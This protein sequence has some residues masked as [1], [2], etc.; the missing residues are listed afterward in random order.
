MSYARIS[1]WLRTRS[2]L[3]T[4]VTVAPL[5]VVILGLTACV[6]YPIGD[7]EKSKV[8]SE[9]VG[10][11][12]SDDSILFFRPYDTR[13]YLISAFTYSE[14]DGQYEAKTRIDYKAWLTP[15]GDETFITMQPLTIAHFVGLGERPPYF[16]AQ[17]RLV[18]D[19][20]QLRLVNAKNVSVQEATNS[21]ELE[22]AI[23]E[24]MSSDSLYVGDLT[25]LK[26]LEDTSRIEAVLEAFPAEFSF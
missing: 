7:P 1:R 23:K 15:V 13:T 10:S 25:I 6:K 24:H 5:I 22:A 18:D 2:S 26:K 19:E 14:T 3:V 20:L 21:S 11:W 12:S 8:N 4:L 9:F 16:V 17:I